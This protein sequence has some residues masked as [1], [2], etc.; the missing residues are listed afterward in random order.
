[1]SF[2]RNVGIFKSSS[3]MFTHQLPRTSFDTWS[4]SFT[5]GGESV[6]LASDSARQNNS[7]ETQANLSW[8]E[9]GRFSPFCLE[10]QE[11]RQLQVVQDHRRPERTDRR[12]CY[13]Y[14][15]YSHISVSANFMQ[16]H[17][18]CLFVPFLLLLRTNQ[19]DPLLEMQQWAIKTHSHSQ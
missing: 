19:E 4:S 18:V 3:K 12:I 17:N 16:H 5:L 7:I 13:I 11:N 9:R 10:N 14:M 15:Y 6:S 2:K 8:T 1:M